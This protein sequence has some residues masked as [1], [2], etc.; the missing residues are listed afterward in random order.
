MNEIYKLYTVEQA[1]DPRVIRNFSGY[2]PIVK[3]QGEAL[4]I[5]ICR[6]ILKHLDDPL[7]IENNIN[8]QTMRDIIKLVLSNDNLQDIKDYL[9]K[10][11]E[12][13]QW[14]SI[15]E[16]IGFAMMTKGYVRV[17]QY[18][19]ERK[20]YYIIDKVKH[21]DSTME[22]IDVYFSNSHYDLMMAP[23]IYQAL[24][25]AYP[26]LSDRVVKNNA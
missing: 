6:W 26:F 23:H 21:K 9:K 12:N 22:P 14:G 4:R 18:N 15:I 24:V 10:L 1:T 7:P 25:C 11:S 5:L 20:E 2:S 17:W 16:I 19:P 13:Y 8:S 3:N